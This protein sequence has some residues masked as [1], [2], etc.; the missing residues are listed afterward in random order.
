M[1][2]RWAFLTR[3]AFTQSSLH[4]CIFS[5]IPGSVGNNSYQFQNEVIPNASVIR[6]PVMI[7]FFLSVCLFICWDDVIRPHNEC[8]AAG[9]KTC[10]DLHDVVC[11]HGCRWWSRGVTV[12]E[13]KETPQIPAQAHRVLVKV[14]SSFTRLHTWVM[15][16]PDSHY[17]CFLLPDNLLVLTLW[18]S[19][20]PLGVFLSSKVIFTWKRKYLYITWPLPFKLPYLRANMILCIVSVKVKQWK[21]GGSESNL[22]VAENKL[23]SNSKISECSL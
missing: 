13:R 12:K 6:F 11:Q 18:I 19:C 7:V 9:L 21:N 17:D 14:S 3:K 8:D 15:E 20:W 23:M 22:I 10:C 2:V 1:K 4:I 5:K 16:I